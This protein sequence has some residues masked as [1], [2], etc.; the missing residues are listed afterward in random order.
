MIR[1][2]IPLLFVLI[3]VFAVMAPLLR[4]VVLKHSAPPPD[5][6]GITN[7]ELAAMH[8]GLN[9][10]SASYLTLEMNGIG[11]LGHRKQAFLMPFIQAMTAAQNSYPGINNPRTRKARE[12]D[13]ESRAAFAL[14]YEDAKTWWNRFNN[15]P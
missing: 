5:T 11:T 1:L 8:A 2:V 3:V 6:S 12:R 14:H 15:E 10:L 7:A 13:M 9:Q 4:A